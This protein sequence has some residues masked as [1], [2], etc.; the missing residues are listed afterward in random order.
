[1]TQRSRR[2]TLLAVLVPEEDFREG[3]LRIRVVCGQKE[4]FVYAFDFTD[5]MLI[6]VSLGQCC[7]K[8]SHLYRM[9]RRA[10]GVLFCFL[11]LLYYQSHLNVQGRFDWQLTCVNTGNLY[12]RLSVSEGQPEALSGSFSITNRRVL[13][14]VL[15]LCCVVYPL[16]VILFHFI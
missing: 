8:H 1:M 13:G 9:S 14:Y 11:C 2:L 10:V 15:R 3:F 4:S 5:T 12:I 16:K 6:D 7:F